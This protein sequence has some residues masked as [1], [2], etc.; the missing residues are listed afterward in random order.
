M[1]GAPWRTRVLIGLTLLAAPVWSI[2]TLALGLS[3]GM[4]S[5]GSSSGAS[6]FDAV[7]FLG[8]ALL[9]VIPPL[10]LSIGLYGKGKAKPR[11][12]MTGIYLLAGW[13]LLVAGLYAANR[14][15]SGP[16][17]PGNW[18]DRAFR[19]SQ[20][21]R[22]KFHMVRYT[23]VLALRLDDPKLIYP[24][25]DSTFARGMPVRA[26]IGDHHLPPITPA[27]G[28][29]CDGALM[30]F[31]R[32]GFA[33]GND[34]FAGSITAPGFSDYYHSIDRRWVVECHLSSERCTNWF[35]NGALTTSFTIKKSDICQASDV[36]R[37][38]LALVTPWL[39]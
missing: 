4:A 30:Q 18:S 10:G 37:R 1:I 33:A 17:A 13:L 39:R 20:A 26:R 32:I 35:R 28:R 23:D 29:L 38:L 31:T 2:F 22:T 16:A 24:Q 27:A 21:D 3:L 36:N 25:A 34:I 14:L 12:E 5:A 19:I 6:I 11:L 7:G 9:P 15:T 8:L